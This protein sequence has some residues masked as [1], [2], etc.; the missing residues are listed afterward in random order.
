MSSISLISIEDLSKDIAINFS[1]VSPIL[2]SSD[3]NPILLSVLLSKSR[4]ISLITVDLPLPVPEV[5]KVISPCLIPCSLSF[6]PSRH[7]GYGTDTVSCLS[8]K[9]SHIG[10]PTTIP[11]GDH[12]CAS[13][14]ACSNA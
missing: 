11:E 4:A 3:T 7:S 13:Q 8:L 10:S 14:Y 6:K 5:N 1:A 2:S 12:V 9:L